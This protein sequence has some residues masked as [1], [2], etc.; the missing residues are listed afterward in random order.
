[1][2]HFPLV[3]TIVSAVLASMLGALWCGPICGAAWLRA[4]GKTKEQIKGGGGAIAIAM[5]TWLVGAV[6]FSA[7]TKFSGADGF[8]ALVVLAVFGWLGFAMMAMVL[9]TTFQE[10]NPGMLWIDGSYQLICWLLMAIVHTLI[11]AIM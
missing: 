2:E 10:K 1:M 7:L 11:P 9:T 6:V 8:Q 5:V 3:A 4:V